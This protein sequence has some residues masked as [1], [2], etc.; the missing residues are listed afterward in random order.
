MKNK[1]LFIFILIAFSCNLFGQT[2]FQ[3]KLK[4]N[5]SIFGVD[6]MENSNSGYNIIGNININDSSYIFNSKLN[7][8]GNVISSKYFVSTDKIFSNRFIQLNY[9]QLIIGYSKTNTDTVKG[10]VIK[11]D[12]NGNIIWSRT[13]KSG[14]ILRFNDV[15][16]L[17]DK[18]CI[19]VGLNDS[20]NND[21][22]VFVTRIDSLGQVLFA[23]TYNENGNEYG[24]SIIRLSDN[25]YA[26]VGYSTTNDPFGDILVMKIDSAGNKLWSKSYDININSLKKQTGFG[27]AENHKGEIVVCGS[28][29]NYQFS[30]GDEAWG[31]VV[32]WIDQNGNLNKMKHYSINSGRCAAYQI[33]EL[34]NYEYIINGK[35]GVN[36]VLAGKLDSSGTAL[37]TTFYPSIGENT[38]AS[39]SML[40]L[41]QNEFIIIGN[42]YSKVDTTAFLIKTKNY[43]TSDCNEGTPAGQGSSSSFPTTISNLSL[44]TKNITALSKSIQINISNLNLTDSAFCSNI[45]N[46]INEDTI[47][48]KNIYLYPIPATDHITIENSDQ[49]KDALISIFNIEGEL[50]IQKTTQQVKTEINILNLARGMYFVKVNTA[51]GI[52]VKRFVKE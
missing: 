18:S 4:A 20:L 26:I 32:L 9:G 13:Y 37:W 42:Y 46:D 8:G 39:G 11:T 44:I 19:I 41:N 6:I 16:T 40:V 27:I 3:K 22:S 49:S 43:G 47:S 51:K 25:N 48:I 28:A 2:T 1:K 10:L 34:N 12:N 23:K 15:L 29:E 31:P 36:F 21:S 5:G 45:V 38:A 35:M 30:P 50:F 7:Y 14:K 17:P 24:N 52:E 33:K